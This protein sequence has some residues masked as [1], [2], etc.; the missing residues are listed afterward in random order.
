MF[1][2][3][4]QHNTD[5]GG[6][7][8]R[9]K[10]SS[11]SSSTGEEGD[12]RLC[13]CTGMIFLSMYDISTSI[14]HFHLRMTFLSCVC[15]YVYVCIMCIFLTFLFYL[16]RE[17]TEN[18]DIAMEETMENLTEEARRFNVMYRADRERKRSEEEKV[19]SVI[20]FEYDI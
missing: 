7:K 3:V 18:V 11:V 13:L 20:T 2:P 1:V 14:R 19:S 16:H 10:K 8:M 6:M 4:R 17:L 9:K 15:M 12:M 5:G